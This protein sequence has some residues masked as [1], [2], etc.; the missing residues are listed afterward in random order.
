MNFVLAMLLLFQ[1]IN[2]TYMHTE[3]KSI[4]MKIDQYNQIDDKLILEA[5]KEYVM[6]SVR[7]NF[8][9]EEFKNIND[10]LN[11]AE[12]KEKANELFKKVT[13]FV[14]ESDRQGILPEQMHNHMCNYM[15]DRFGTFRLCNKQEFENFY[16]NHNVTRVVGSFSNDDAAVLNDILRGCVDL[17]KIS[18]IENCMKE[19]YYLN[20]DHSYRYDRFWD[21]GTA[22]FTKNLKDNKIDKK[23]LEESNISTDY[24]KEY[25]SN[26]GKLRWG[27]NETY[28]IFF[29]EYD[30][31]KVKLIDKRFLDAVVC[32]AVCDNLEKLYNNAEYRQFLVMKYADSYHFQNCFSPAFKETFGF[33]INELY[34]QSFVGLNSSNMNDVNFLKKVFKNIES[35]I[36]TA[37]GDL[38]P[39][40]S[41]KMDEL[42][43]A[44]TKV[45]HSLN[46]FRTV[47]KDLGF[48]ASLLGYDVI[49]SERSNSHYWCNVR[50]LL[51]CTDDLLEN[52]VEN[53][54]NSDFIDKHL[55][56]SSNENV[57]HAG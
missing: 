5:L 3:N 26:N 44:S 47:F 16:K 33:D 2:S 38:N 1:N 46:K 45:P 51:F 32:R 31:S 53:S 11:S 28:K 52:D 35:F 49:K 15:C 17:K 4:D 8:G 42:M 27:G 30:T 25:T 14:E 10:L 22:F 43:K 18:P 20:P 9:D 13:Q 55:F 54:N 50:N 24:Y 12:V 57:D 6:D 19:P 21:E 34:K 41:K 23:C 48:L 56:S 37:L 36:A 39:E 7:M 29:L 40:F